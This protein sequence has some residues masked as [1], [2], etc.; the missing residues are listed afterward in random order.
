[1]FV[2]FLGRMAD[3]K[4]DLNSPAAQASERLGLPRDFVWKSE[5]E[6]KRILASLDS[7]GEGLVAEGA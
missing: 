3:R 1:M 7:Q 6:R 2:R 5:N 4:V